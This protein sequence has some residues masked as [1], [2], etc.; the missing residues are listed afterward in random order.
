MPSLSGCIGFIK[1]LADKVRMSSL[2]TR[3]NEIGK[4][5][6]KSPRRISKTPFL[7]F[8]IDL[9][10]LLLTLNADLHV[11]VNGSNGRAATAQFFLDFLNTQIWR[12]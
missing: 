2:S 11:K 6:A 12:A 8:L 1:N 5:M 4:F 7:R 3:P 9:W 10:E